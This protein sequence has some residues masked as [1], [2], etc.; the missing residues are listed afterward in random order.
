VSEFKVGEFYSCNGGVFEVT[1]VS[2]KSVWLRKTRTKQIIR[3]KLY[4][5]AT[6]HI[7]MLGDAVLKPVDLVA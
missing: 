4:D 7:V 3:R 5:A 6:G 2:S 1:R